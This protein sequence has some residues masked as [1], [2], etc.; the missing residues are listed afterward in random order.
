MKV[1]FLNGSPRPIGNTSNI[2]GDVRDV[3]EREGIETEQFDLGGYDFTP[4][5]DC[6]TCEMRGDGRCAVDETDGFNEIM[7]AVRGADG[8]ILAAP[9]YGGY[10]PG[11]M[12]MFLERAVLCNQTGGNG[13]RG[14]V[15]GAIAV[16]EHEGAETAFFEMVQ[17]MLRCEMYVVGTGRLPVFRALNS[18]AYD[19]DTLAL[20]GVGRLEENMISL[21]YRMNGMERD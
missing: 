21:I 18:P 15:G 2:L 19:D 20:R 10:V 4:C 3:F 1:V 7:E 8:V 16:A 11:A 5:N 9:A 12:K 14:K 13:L 6:R 17:W